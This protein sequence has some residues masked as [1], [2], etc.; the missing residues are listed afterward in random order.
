VL[1][2]KRELTEKDL[3]DIQACAFFVQS[4]VH[5][6]ARVVRPEVGRTYGEAADRVQQLLERTPCAG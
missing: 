5:L 1:K 4:V 2:L 6:N 3:Q